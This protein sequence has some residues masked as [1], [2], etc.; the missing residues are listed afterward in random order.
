MPGVVSL[1]RLLGSLLGALALAL[2]IAVT[3][4]AAP[5]LPLPPPT[6]LT[7]APD[8]MG[9]VTVT[10]RVNPDAYVF[11]LDEDRGDGVIVSADAAGTY[12]ATLTAASGDTLTVWQMVGSNTG[13][14]TSSIVP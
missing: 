9:R 8:A 12:T 6:A 3:S 11:V 14:L 7:S 2:A 4:C 5:T 13:Q 1:R 10:G